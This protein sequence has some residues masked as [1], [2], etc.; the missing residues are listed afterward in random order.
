MVRSFIS[1]YL[2]SYPGATSKVYWYI[3]PKPVLIGA[4]KGSPN[5]SGMFSFTSE[6]ASATNCRG[7]YVPASSSKTIVT[8][9][10]PNRETLRISVMSG[11][12]AIASSTW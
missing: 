3:S 10:N 4:I 6:R 5:P 1:S 9:D 12:F 11:K 2:S 7:R 8:T